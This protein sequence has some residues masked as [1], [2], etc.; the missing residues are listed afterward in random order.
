M[1]R[2]VLSFFDGPA[3]LVN[4]KEVRSGV[5][6]IAFLAID[7]HA[8]KGLTALPSV[9]LGVGHVGNVALDVVHNLAATLVEVSEQSVAQV[10]RP[11]VLLRM[12]RYGHSYGRQ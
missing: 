1:V 5:M 12:G 4:P 2:A 9:E 6:K 8:F 10:F 7:G 3:G 11:T